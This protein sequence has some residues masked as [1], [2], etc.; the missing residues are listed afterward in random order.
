MNLTLTVSSISTIKMIT[1][2]TI[3]S[4]FSGNIISTKNGTQKIPRALWQQKYLRV[5][6]YINTQLIHLHF[7]LRK[8]VFDY[9]DINCFF[10]FN[11]GYTF[12]MINVYLDEYQT[13]LKYFKNTE[14]NL[15]DVLVMARDFN[16]RDR[17]WNPSY[18]F[19]LTHSNSFL[20]IADF[21]DFK[22]LC[23]IQQVLTWYAKN[24]NDANSVINL[25]FLHS[26]LV[27]INNH[28]ILPDLHHF[29]DYTPLT[30]DIPIMEENFISKLTN[31]IGNINILNILDRE[32]LKLIIE[33]YV[34]ISEST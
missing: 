12:F 10:F 25:L 34:R 18:L 33:E 17:K 19:Y 2:L 23:S 7:S 13:A 22:L 26:N 8:D 21:F 24:P 14:T 11:N 28:Y 9:R 20:E 1:K 6:T 16:I 3:L 30:I 31:M 4:I 5:H 15:C 32:S 27:K 29:L